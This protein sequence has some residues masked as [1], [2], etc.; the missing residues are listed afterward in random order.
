MFCTNCGKQVP[1]GAKFCNECGTNLITGAA[2]MGAPTAMPNPGPTL[3]GP[4]SIRVTNDASVTAR[5]HVRCEY[6]LCEFEYGISDLGYRAWYPHGFVYCPKCRRPLRH[7]L[8]YRV[9]GT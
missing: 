5:F 2:P 1:D 3:V 4:G 7:R 8:E 9:E 6:C